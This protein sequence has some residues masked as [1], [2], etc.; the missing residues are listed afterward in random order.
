MKP[1]TAINHSGDRGGSAPSPRMILAQEFADALG[2]GTI[3]RVQHGAGDRKRFYRAVLR[4]GV[5][6][7]VHYPTW[8]V[9]AGTVYRN[10]NEARLAAWDAIKKAA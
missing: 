4:P 6:V 1:G 8:I 3:E 5:V 9:V 2:D 7:D 10:A